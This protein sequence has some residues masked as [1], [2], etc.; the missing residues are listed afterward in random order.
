MAK[1]KT[2][3]KK[4]AKKPAAKKAA[5]RKPAAKAS[6]RKVATYEP[7]PVDAARLVDSVERLLGTKALSA[8]GK[9]GAE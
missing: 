3:Q 4:G 7:K 6:S 5:V 2:S 1:K 9:I 8:R